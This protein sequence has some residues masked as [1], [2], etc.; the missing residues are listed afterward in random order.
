MENISW[1]IIVGNDD[2]NTLVIMACT[3]LHLVAYKNKKI[4]KIQ[5]NSHG[6]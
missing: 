6:T 1:Y 4:N 2:T 3:Y 5:F